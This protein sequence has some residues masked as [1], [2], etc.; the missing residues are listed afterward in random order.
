MKIRYP[1]PRHI[2]VTLYLVF[3]LFPVV[4]MIITSIKPP[5]ELTAYPVIF[6]PHRIDWNY[7]AQVFQGGAIDALMT[8]VIVAVVNTLV[9]LILGLPAAYSIARWNT[10]GNNLSFWFLS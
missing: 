9:S 6:I 5:G 3:C 10:G 8:S 7:Y 4:W 1:R 2:L